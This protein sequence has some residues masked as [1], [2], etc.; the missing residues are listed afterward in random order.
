MLKQSDWNN[1]R[2]KVTWMPP[3]ACSSPDDLRSR[4]QDGLNLKRFNWGKHLCEWD[5]Q[6]AVEVGRPF[7]LRCKFD[8]EWKREGEGVGW[9]YP[10]LV[11][12]LREGTT[13]LKESKSTV[14][15]VSPPRTGSASISLGS[16]IGWEHQLGLWPQHKCGWLSEELRLSPSVPGFR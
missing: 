1:Q 12:L 13:N 9:K 5:L 2:R 8:P 7:S 14:R 4:C 3:C 10:R 6:G 11:W 15:G 16:G